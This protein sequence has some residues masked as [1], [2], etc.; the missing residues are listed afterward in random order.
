M[1]R[2]RKTKGPRASSAAEAPPDLTKLTGFDLLVQASGAHVRD[3]TDS[4]PIDFGT[5]KK[6]LAIID[7]GYRRLPPIYEDPFLN[8]LKKLTTDVEY[9]LILERLH[10]RGNGPWSDWLAAIGQRQPGSL[11]KATQA[12]EE[13]ISDLYD[14]FLS[15]EERRGVKPP[16]HQTVSPL[17]KWGNPRSGPYTWPATT[18]LR[19]G[20]EMSVVSMPPAYARNIALWAALGHETGGH[21]ILHADEGLLAEIATLVERRILDAGKK[22]PLRGTF[23]QVNGRRVPVAEFAAYYWKHCIDETASD[24]CGLINLGPAAGVGLAVLLIPIRN[25]T[26]PTVNHVEDVHPIDALRIFLAAEVVEDIPDLELSLARAWSKALAAVADQYI[27]NKSG[28]GLYSVDAAGNPYWEAVIPYEPMLETVRV[29]ASTIAFTPLESLENHSLSEINTWSNS[30][31][32]LT[33]RLAQ[34]FLSGRSPSLAAG[35]AGETIYAAHVLSAAV[36]ALA[37][38]APIE[39]STERAINALVELY[40]QNPVWRGFPVRYRGDVYQHPFVFAYGK[41]A[42]LLPKRLAV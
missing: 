9:A 33:V 34:D 12:F 18:G 5:Q 6:A 23:A 35:P 16:D 25:N 3:V 36:L 27:P 21:D 14:G 40:N 41:K 26:L 38:G 39:P 32:R 30:D 22:R 29:V 42:P 37:N 13:T 7:S 20:M 1:K 11:Q 8:P 24:V 31:E 4:A 17:V 10:A 19:L 28:F 15:M 2:S